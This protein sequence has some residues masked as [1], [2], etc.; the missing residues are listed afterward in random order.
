MTRLERGVIDIDR[1]LFFSFFLVYRCLGHPG[2]LAHHASRSF[3]FT[4]PADL[5]GHDDGR[6]HLETIPKVPAGDPVG[7][8]SKTSHTSVL[9]H[10]GGGPDCIRGSLLW[11][12]DGP[13]GI[14]DDV[15]VG[16][17]HAGLVL[18]KIGR[19]E[20]KVPLDK[21]MGL[22]CSGHWTRCYGPGHD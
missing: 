13:F 11:G 8:V 15:L 12:C 21:D 20:E 16:V 1:L 3:G 6:I 7:A 10:L 2:Q 19:T 9:D 5:F 17:Y 18:P 14:L 22:V 4:H